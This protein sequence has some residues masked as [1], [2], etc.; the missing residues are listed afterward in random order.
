MK[1]PKRLVI[2]NINP[3]AQTRKGCNAIRSAFQSLS[4]SLDVRI[5]HWTQITA[6]RIRQLRPQALIIGPNDTPFPA[7]PGRF[8]DFLALLRRRRGP[9]LG[10]C[11]GHQAIALA[12]GAPVGPVYD[13]PAARSSY[14]GM[15][16]FTGE[17]VVRS[18]GDPDPLL[19]GLPQHMR[20][21]A[22]H[23]DEVKEVPDGFRLL[24]LGEPAFI[25]I[26]RA[27]KRPIWGV[28]F[29]PER[30]DRHPD[31]RRLL[32]NFLRFAGATRRSS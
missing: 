15:P 26:I 2:V 32:N 20:F 4:P 13:V 9:T 3:S 12:H 30:W 8:D 1:R 5:V 28:Q 29:H 31:G 6:K 7:Y 25:Q 23:V 22:S 27:D 21:Q 19:A 17:L 11:G 16:K 18:L 10:I 14:A 24:A